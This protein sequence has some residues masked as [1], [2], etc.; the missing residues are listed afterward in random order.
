[1]FNNRHDLVEKRKGGKFQNSFASPYK[2]TQNPNLFNGTHNKDNI[3]SGGQ[4]K[5]RN[6]FHKRAKSMMHATIATTQEI[7]TLPDLSKDSGALHRKAS[8]HIVMTDS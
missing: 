3:I 4:I 1:M 7:D 2:I 5:S 8:L 6:N